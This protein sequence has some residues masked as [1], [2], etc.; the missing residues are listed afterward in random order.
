M[1]LTATMRAAR[2]SRARANLT[3]ELATLTS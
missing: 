1:F 3:A 2:E